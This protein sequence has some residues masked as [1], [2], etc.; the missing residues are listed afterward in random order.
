MRRAAGID[1]SYPL[2]CRQMT[3]DGTTTNKDD[4]STL[5]STPD[6]PA[7]Y[8]VSASE[9]GYV[10]TV[11]EDAHLDARESNLWV[12]A[13]GMGGHSFGD[14]ASR[15]VIEQLADFSPASSADNS[16]EDIKHRLKSANDICR[17]EAS[18]KVMG[19][20]VA[21]LYLSLIHI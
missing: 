11:N 14:K 18:G 9:T 17:D 1:Q 4:P 16:L 21:A 6:Q 2:Q 13:D 8:S 12:V 10:R 15:T 7:W 3:S 20:T 5:G 19:T